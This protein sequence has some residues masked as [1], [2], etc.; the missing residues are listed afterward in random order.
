MHCLDSATVAWIWII[1]PIPTNIDRV[2]SRK[3]MKKR[4]KGN[5]SSCVCVWTDWN[6]EEC[7]D[8]NHFLK[9]KEMHVCTGT[10]WLSFSGRISEF[11][12]RW[13]VEV[14]R[15]FHPL[16]LAVHSRT[17]LWTCCIQNCFFSGLEFLKMWLRLIDV[18]AC[19][20]YPLVSMTM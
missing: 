7:I 12:G 16:A 14:W 2:A 4:Y 10:S 1:E 9:T 11:I 13:F 15:L 3:S 6:H 19:I 20:I 5:N 18:G 8:L 17:K